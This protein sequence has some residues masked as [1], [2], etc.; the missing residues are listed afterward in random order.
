MFSEKIVDNLTKSSWIRAMFEEGEK[1]R[2]IYGADKVFDFS[3]GNPDPEPPEVTKDTLKRLVLEDKPKM[4]GYMPNAGYPDVREKVAIQISKETNVPLTMKNIVMTCG[5]GAALNVALKAIL[6]P[7]EEVIVFAPFFVEYLS[8]IDNNG[9]KGVIVKSNKDTFE[10]DINALEASITPK[11]KAVIV[12]TPNN[13]TG[14]VYSESILKNMAEVL[15]KKEKEFNTT[16][17]VI[18]DEPYRKVVY[19]NIKLPSAL[20][21]FENSIMVDSFS[22]SLS[23]PGERIGYIAVSPYIKDV[24]LLIDAI[25]YCNRVLGF[26][27]APALFQKVIA[28]SVDTSVDINIYKE[29][30]DLLYNSLIKM[31]YSCIKPQGAFYLFPKAFIEDDIE[32]KNRALKYNLLLVPG[33]GF[34]CPGYFRISYC[35][36]LKTIENSL[37]AFEALAKEFI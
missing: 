19:D 27:N 18:S 33:S 3:I 20:K 6:N 14:V 31:G 36:S 34:Y 16:I 17:F 22:K 37:P 5:A 4:H 25:V 10:P 21:I 32:F 15:K 7:G 28:E 30:R 35:V 9:G 26:V 23:L 12:N 2:K 8:Y 13:P 29:R 1:L 24:D 11:T